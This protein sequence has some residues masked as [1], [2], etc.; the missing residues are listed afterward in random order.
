MPL[1][2]AREQ[3]ISVSSV[4]QVSAKHTE[5]ATQMTR[6]Q[7]RPAVHADEPRSP[8]APG[9][10]LDPDSGRPAIG[11]AEWIVV[12]AHWY[13]APG[14][15]LALAAFAVGVKRMGQRIGALFGRRPPS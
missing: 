1:D 5:E 8:R 10:P 4:N 7:R 3:R 9:V 15:V 12:N 13:A 2:P 6:A 11:W 14:P